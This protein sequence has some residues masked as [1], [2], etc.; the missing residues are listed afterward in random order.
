MASTKIAFDRDGDVY[1]LGAAGRSGVLLHSRDGGKTFAAYRIPGREGQVR[2][3]DFEVFSGHN[4]PDGPPPT[5]RRF[6]I[7]SAALQFRKL[8][9]K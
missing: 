7:N 8:A 3:L 2:D 1:L 9:G 4:V 6:C 5:G